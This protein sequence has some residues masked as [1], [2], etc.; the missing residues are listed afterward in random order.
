MMLL[1]E[2]YEKNPQIVMI[3]GFLLFPIFFSVQYSLLK[4]AG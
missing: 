4:S 2:H 3:C 1:F